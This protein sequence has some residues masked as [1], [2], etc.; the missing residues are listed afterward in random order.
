MFTV[1]RSKKI[2][3]RIEQQYFEPFN[4][5]IRQEPGPRA[6]VFLRMVYC[7]LESKIN[8]AGSDN[9]RMHFLLRVTYVLMDVT[10]LKT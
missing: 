5:T 2:T 4:Y 1:S 9:L 3:G 10:L 6:F 7:I 8:N